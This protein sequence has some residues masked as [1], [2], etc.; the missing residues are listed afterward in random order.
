MNEQPA[1]PGA[2]GPARNGAEPVVPLSPEDA[3]QLTDAT[4][5]DW[6]E[7]LLRRPPQQS[8]QHQG[9]A[10]NNHQQ[11]NQQQNQQ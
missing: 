2:N 8:I 1:A 6:F 5:A 11:Q 9:A 7:D 4:A 10:G 3:R